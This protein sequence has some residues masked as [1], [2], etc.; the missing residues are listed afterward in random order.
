MVITLVSIYFDRRRL[1]HT[2]KINVI[3][4]QRVDPEVY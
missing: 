4:F 3:T 1:V 2:I